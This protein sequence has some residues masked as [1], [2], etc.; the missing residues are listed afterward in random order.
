MYLGFLKNEK[1]SKKR[2]VPFAMPILSKIHKYKDFHKGESCYL[3]GDEVSIKWFDLGAFTDKVA[4]SSKY[5]PFHKDFYKLNVQYLLLT[6]PWWFYPIRKVKFGN[7]ILVNDPRMRA[8][9]K[10]I[11]KNKEKSFFVN[12]S[13]YFAV[14]GPNVYYLFQDIHDCRLPNDFIS[15]RIDAFY[16]SIRAS[17]LLAIYMGFDKAYLVGF[18]YTHTESRSRHWY[19]K[20]QGIFVPQHNYNKEFFEVA[21]QFIDIVSITLDGGSRFL[22]YVKYEEYTGLNS[23]YRENTELVDLEYLKVL[24]SHPKYDIF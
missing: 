16:G 13:N 7:G 19:E 11:K 24:S 1:L 14:G 23:F 3:F 22:D 18:D 20:G 21:K 10:I 6:E 15:H 12:L 8:Y 2:L 5:I 9:R 17:V 4:L